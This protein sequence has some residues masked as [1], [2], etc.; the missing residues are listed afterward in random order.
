VP[1]SFVFGE[2]QARGQVSVIAESNPNMDAKGLS[3][4]GKGLDHAA[5]VSAGAG[6]GLV[7][8]CHGSLLGGPGPA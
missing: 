2:K 4:N 8:C 3:S 6:V 7:S 5:E 1:T